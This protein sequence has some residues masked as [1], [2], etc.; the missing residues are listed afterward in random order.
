[1]CVC[2]CACV[3]CVLVCIYV[4]RMCACG[5]RVQKKG[6]KPQ[7]LNLQLGAILSVSAGTELGSSARAASP[8]NH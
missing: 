8:P 2:M 5:L 7:E 4:Y 3:C 1:M 6:L